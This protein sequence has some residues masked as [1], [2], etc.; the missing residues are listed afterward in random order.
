VCGKAQLATNRHLCQRK[1]EGGLEKVLA[2]LWSR[3]K[4]A[5]KPHASRGQETIWEIP[6]NCPGNWSVSVV[7]KDGSVTLKQARG[8]FGSDNIFITAPVSNPDALKSLQKGQKVRIMGVLTKCEPGNFVQT[9][10]LE[11]AEILDK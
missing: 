3:Q 7:G 10:Y 1:N 9:L 4:I 2:N 6:V 8:L 5:K 11:N